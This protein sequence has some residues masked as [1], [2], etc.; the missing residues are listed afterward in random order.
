M[1]SC[2]HAFQTPCALRTLRI[3][4]FT[5]MRSLS[6]LMVDGYPPR[7]AFSHHSTYPVWTS[8]SHRS[9][10]PI[11]IL[12]LERL[13]SVSELVLACVYVSCFHFVIDACFRPLSP[14]VLH[15]RAQQPR[16]TGSSRRQGDFLP[17]RCFLSLERCF[18]RRRGC[19]ETR[20]QGEMFGA[21]SNP[22]LCCDESCQSFHHVT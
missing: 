1:L 13:A 6:A 7:T 11:A 2:P 14:P 8:G 20:D 9:T 5:R 12:R 16:P 17:P 22:A 18:T 10:S 3:R 19:R 21:S 15:V 4:P